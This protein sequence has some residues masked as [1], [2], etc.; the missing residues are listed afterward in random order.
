[1][2]LLVALV[3]LVPAVSFAAGV[4]IRDKC[5]IT[6]DEP[7]PGGPPRDGYRILW[8]PTSGVHPNSV[9]VPDVPAAQ[10]GDFGLVEGG[11]YPSGQYYM[12]VRAYDSFGVSEASNERPFF[13]GLG[14]PSNLNIG[15]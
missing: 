12:V 10:C 3:L 5:T 9:D 7:A 14:S 6:W 11:S 8:G 15:P 13:L 1:M 4:N 2:R